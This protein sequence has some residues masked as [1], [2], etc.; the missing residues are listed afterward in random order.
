MSPSTSVV[1]LARLLFLPFYGVP[2]LRF[3]GLSTPPLAKS[4]LGMNSGGAPRFAYHS[5]SSH[6]VSVFTRGNGWLYLSGNTDVS[7]CF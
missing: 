1:S 4:N 2:A 7:R 3:P 6:N 5:C